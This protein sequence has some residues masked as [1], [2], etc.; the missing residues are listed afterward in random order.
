MLSFLIQAGSV[1]SLNVWWEARGKYL[2]RAASAKNKLFESLKSDVQLKQ[3]N[4]LVDEKKDEKEDKVVADLNPAE[5]VKVEED[6]KPDKDAK[7]KKG[8]GKDKKDTS[9][10][11]LSKGDKGKNKK[12]RYKK[13][14]KAVKKNTFLKYLGSVGPGSGDGV[15][16]T[17]KDGVTS[18]KINDAWNLKGGI[19]VAKQGDHG[20]F[21]AEGP[22]SK[23]AKGGGYAKLSGKKYKKKLSTGTVKIASKKKEMAVKV[24]IGGQMGNVFGLG[25][26]N[27]GKVASVFRRKQKAIRYC[28]EKRLK[29]NPNISGKVRVQF[30]VGPMGNVTGINIL[31]NTT[32]DSS[33]GACIMS[34]IKGWRFP[35]PQNGQVTIIHTIV[36]QKG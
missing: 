31:Q 22:N 4:L 15:E 21:V 35:R 10:A 12:L 36:L 9:G 2:V 17:L 33:L 28:Y 27:K 23:V 24:K 14:V 26:I 13:M 5:D 20:Q 6:V 19:E 7:G 8:K 1:I 25:K 32:N 16:N 11:L 3:K 30:T 29:I 34:K 18:S